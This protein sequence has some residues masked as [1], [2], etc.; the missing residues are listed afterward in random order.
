[1]ASK[2]LFKWCLMIEI[3]ITQSKN[4]VISSEPT[5][6]CVESEEKSY[7]RDLRT[8]PIA[9]VF[10]SRQANSSPCSFEMT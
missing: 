6:P 8:I 7:T 2:S 10:S 1:M 9:E 5:G 3:S 4:H